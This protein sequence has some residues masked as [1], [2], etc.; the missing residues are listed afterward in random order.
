MTNTIRMA[1]LLAALSLAA[2][3]T[4][5][6]SR[7]DGDEQGGGP[8]SEQPDEREEK[9]FEIRAR[10]E[11][12]PVLYTLDG[13]QLHE[14][15]PDGRVVYVRV[16]N[17]IRAGSKDGK[18]AFFVKENDLRRKNAKGEVLLH[19]SEHEIRRTADPDSET[20]F[21][22]RGTDVWRR[23]HNGPSV[24]FVDRGTPKWAVACALQG[25]Y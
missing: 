14:G 6:G 9:V 17:E 7:G 10:N 22:W 13:D 15:G 20:L 25:M 2:C 3:E 24:L 1:C 21:L 8:P 5:S 23:D 19:F 11:K 4:T 18:E 12:G 16:G